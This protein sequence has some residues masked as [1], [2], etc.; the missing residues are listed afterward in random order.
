MAVVEPLK[1]SDFAFSISGG[2]ASLSS[3]TPSSLSASGNVYILGITLS[4][5]PNGSETLTVNP[6]ANSIFDVTGNVA[7]TSQSNNTTKLNLKIDGYVLLYEQ[8]NHSGIKIKFSNTMSSTSDSV[9]TDNNGYYLNYIK[10]GIYN[11]EFSKDDY[12]TQKADN[13]F[14]NANNTLDQRTLL[15]AKS[16]IS[17]KLL[18]SV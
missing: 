10:Q 2:T 13:L 7:S 9:F 16:I 12:A 4:G 15:P 11:V 6:V 17:G 8:T 5:T 14:I 3:T 18:L 1:T